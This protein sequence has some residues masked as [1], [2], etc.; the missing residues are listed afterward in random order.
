MSSNKQSKPGML[1]LRVTCL[2]LLIPTGTV[3]A[4]VIHVDDHAPPAGDGITWAAA[5]KYLQD[6]LATAQPGDEIRVAEGTY[7]PD[8]SEAGLTTPQDR[9]ASFQLLS[10]VTLRGGYAG[11]TGLDPDERNLA[12]YVSVL[13]G[14][15]AG[16]DAVAPP[17][18]SENAYH[19]VLGS[20]VDETAVL[21]GFLITAGNADLDDGIASR[22]GG[23]YCMSGSPTITHCHFVD[24]YALVLGG[25]LY[26]RDSQSQLV[27]CVFE[28][29]QS[30]DGGGGVNTSEGDSEFVNCV[31]VGNYGSYEGG[32]IRNVDGTVTLTNC[33]FCGNFASE[34]GGLTN[35]E[36][37][38][39][40][41]TNCTFAQ[42][43][44][45]VGPAISTGCG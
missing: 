45:Y 12:G 28:G 42:N 20:G 3:S 2:C 16:D 9:A 35:F 26:L 4:V 8:R 32:G 24:N 39:A 14:D 23:C 31:F 19:V 15:L 40:I 5:F 22:G 1:R 30:D 10:G 41:V 36:T 34:G 33:T 13:S 29:N 21:D 37:S 6:A 38:H 43:E 18:R 44:A 17:A 11:L 25:A 7:K 27:N